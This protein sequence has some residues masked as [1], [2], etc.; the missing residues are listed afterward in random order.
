LEE[1]SNEDSDAGDVED[2]NEAK[3]DTQ[4]EDSK[5]PQ[6]K[7]RDIDRT[8]PIAIIQLINKS[9]SENITEQ[10]EKKFKAIQDLIGMS[11][12]NTS[13][14]SSIINIRLKMYKELRRISEHV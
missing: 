1:F 6:C 7:V 14:Q 4:Q 9:G 11:I 12:D 3:D 10:D 2:S 8:H 13:E 5:H